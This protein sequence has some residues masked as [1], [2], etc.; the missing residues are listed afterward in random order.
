M[1]MNIAGFAFSAASLAIQLGEIAVE[2]TKSKRAWFATSTLDIDTEGLELAI[3]HECEQTQLLSAIITKGKFGLTRASLAEMSDKDQELLFAILDQLS[4][5]W[6]DINELRKK[7]EQ[8][9]PEQ[10]SS[11]ESETRIRELEEGAVVKTQKLRMATDVDRVR[12]MLQAA[13]EW[14]D[15][16]ER[17]LRALTWIRTLS[18]SSLKTSI[19]CLNTVANDPEA[20]RLGWKT[21]AQL[22]QLVLA[23]ANPQIDRSLLPIPT[24]LRLPDS[25]VS[26]ISNASD[27]GLVG[28]NKIDRS[29]VFVEFLPYD[30]SQVHKDEGVVVRRVEQL[31]A[32]LHL[33]KESTFRLPVAA[34]FYDDSNRARYGIVFKIS[35][36]TKYSLA[37][38][39]SLQ[40][41]LQNISRP[42]SSM[43]RPSLGSRLKLAYKLSL[44]LSKIQSIGWVHQGIRS[45]NILFWTQNGTTADT[46]S[47]PFDQPWW[48]GYGS[49]RPDTI[50]S[51]A[52]YDENPIRN[53]YRHPARWG[54]QPAERFTKLHDI[55][56]LGVVLL[57]IGCCAPASQIVREELTKPG[58]SSVAVKEDL[59][60]LA[61]HARITDLMGERYA[62]IIELCLKSTAIEFGVPE[63]EDNKD[64]SLLQ[65]AFLTQVV[66]VLHNAAEAVNQGSLV[67][68]T[69]QSSSIDNYDL[70]LG[71]YINTCVKAGVGRSVVGNGDRLRYLGEG[72]SFTVYRSKIQRFSDD[73]SSATQP[74]VVKM[75]RGCPVGE[76]PNNYPQKQG[77]QLKQLE[78]IVKEVRV[79]LHPPLSAHENILNLLE[80]GFNTQGG[81]I[82]ESNDPEWQKIQPFLV[83]EY[84]EERSLRQFMQA[85]PTLESDLLRE[86]ALDMAAGLEA[87]HACEIVHGDFKLDNVLIFKHPDHGFLAK[88]SDFSHSIPMK[89]TSIYLGTQKYWPPE[90]LGSGENVVLQHKE[91][92]ACDVWSFG[93]SVFELLRG[94]EWVSEG[95]EEQILIETILSDEDL[96]SRLSALSDHQ[97]DMWTI[98]LQDTLQSNPLKRKEMKDV[99]ILLDK[100]S[101]RTTPKNEIVDFE[102]MTM[103]EMQ[104]CHAAFD[105]KYRHLQMAM[106]LAFRGPHSSKSRWKFQVAQAHTMGVGVPVDRSK[107]QYAYFFAIDITSDDEPEVPS[108]PTLMSTL[109]RITGVAS[110]IKGYLSEEITA[111]NK[112]LAKETNEKYYSQ[113]LRVYR[114]GTVMKLKSMDL[115]FEPPLDGILNWQALSRY[116]TE[117]NRYRG[118]VTIA[119]N[120]LD[121]ADLDNIPI[122]HF[123]CLIGD[124]VAVKRFTTEDNGGAD[125]LALEDDKGNTALHFACMGGHTDVVLYLV[126]EKGVTISK[127]N[128]IGT[129]PLHWLFMF[130][131]QDIDKVAELLSHADIVNNASQGLR[132]PLHLLWLRGPPIHWAVSCRNQTAVQSLIRIGANVDEEYQGYTA[133]A[134]AV[135]LHTPEMV[136]LL[137]EN[138]AQFTSIG[139]FSRSA[140]HFIAGNA[141]IIKRRLLHGTRHARNQDL[142]KA[143]RN[144]ITKLEFFGCNINSRDKYGNTPLHKAVASPLERGDIDDLYVVRALI[145]NDADRNVQNSEGDTILHLAIKS[146][147]CDK[148][149]HMNLFKLLLDDSIPL[150][151]ETPLQIT[152]KDRNG[153][154]PLLLAAFMG[155]GADY[156]RMLQTKVIQDREVAVAVLMAVDNYGKN[157]IALANR[158]HEE[159]LQFMHSEMKR[160]GDCGLGVTLDPECS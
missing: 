125:N 81:E 22:R 158:P 109:E 68:T 56:S 57:E 155:D 122:L 65:T 24:S 138:G 147:W 72:A 159:R 116:I 66:E 107:A 61:R 45:E 55:Y 63:G 130:P 141:P 119:E 148:P 149:N 75:L 132:I 121:M 129:V 17:R 60:S 14:N 19:D 3:R 88:L 2:I 117:E 111:Y 70:P 113:R 6:T 142:K 42:G 30:R 31:T 41:V 35:D 124:L 47:I 77:Y 52:L 92:L 28:L 126:Q 151:D 153:R 53:L 76:D 13:T 79:L 106:Y 101:R 78:A 80:Y 94:K 95:D 103:L 18:M 44:S 67:A 49:S 1:A 150:T 127:H 123:L 84:A 156:V 36:M 110:E 10:P 96:G 26:G 152:Q 51:A 98:L 89:S 104:A 140:M 43:H 39:T 73:G 134:K 11:S 97:V 62:S 4:R 144:T 83:L 54:S 137:L 58:A 71:E 29:R 25:C 90:L 20:Q 59:L 133:L 139:E 131:D 136:H 23:V 102:P 87:L 112:D 27:G 69:S 5:I 145:Q 21:P 37:K 64:D 38:M 82:D 115:H 114:A 105:E 120:M 33:P 85:H 32:L 7:Q 146:Y 34:G 99:R 8:E 74:S 108:D 160:L 9:I 12:V 118:H 154:H 50:P 128:H 143:L 157:F 16:L 91:L 15:R 46:K 40:T 93:V 48:I 86:L 135:E 100:H